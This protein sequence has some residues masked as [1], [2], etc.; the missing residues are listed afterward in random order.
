VYALDAAGQPLPQL[1]TRFLFV[2]FPSQYEEL[3][4][5]GSADAA[6]DGAL[7][8]DRRTALGPQSASAS[9]RSAAGWNR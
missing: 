4:G 7:R 8:R 9:D 3:R 1:P 5:F 2:E 6:A